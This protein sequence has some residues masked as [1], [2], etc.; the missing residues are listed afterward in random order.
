MTAMG[1]KCLTVTSACEFSPPQ[2]KAVQECDFAYFA[3][4]M[5]PFADE[6]RFRAICDWGNWIFPYDDLFDNGTMRSDYDQAAAAMDTLIKSSDDSHK[7]HSEH[8]L[9]TNSVSV[10]KL[11]RF[12]GS[13]WNSIRSST[14]SGNRCSAP[15]YTS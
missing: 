7:H 15:T 9:Q 4:I 11:A 5:A 8:T 14:P 6:R 13:I 12:H 3:A 10:T 1:S 2:K